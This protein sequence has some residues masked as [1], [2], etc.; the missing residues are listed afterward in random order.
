LGGASLVGSSPTNPGLAAAG[1]QGGEGVDVLTGLS[2]SFG[3]TSLSDPAPSPYVLS[4][5]G[6]LGNPNYN[7]VARIDGSWSVVGSRP[8]TDYF[9]QTSGIMD[10]ASSPGF[11]PTCGK[12]E[13]TDA[14]PFSFDQAATGS[15]LFYVDRRFGP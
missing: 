11:L 13:G 4:V 10:C 12:A 14:E 9:T 1:L 5:L 3:I 15:T 7:I 6:T 2:N 8:G